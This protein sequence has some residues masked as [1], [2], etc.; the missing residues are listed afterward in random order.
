[1][2]MKKKIVIV[3]LVVCIFAMSIAS[4]TL[5]YFTDTE[6]VKNTFTIGDVK[7]TLTEAG[8]PADGETHVFSYGDLFPGFGK[9]LSPTI[10]NASVQSD[11]NDAYVAAI[12]TLEATDIG[13]IVK[14]DT[15]D[16]V[17]TENVFSNANY[18]V[19]IT[20]TNDLITI[21]V[22]ALN[23]LE[24]GDTVVLFKDVFAL[25]TWD[26]AEMD[27]IATLKLDIEAYAVQTAGFDGDAVKAI[28]TAFDGKF[29]SHK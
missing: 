2:T 21:S 9:E 22:I 12:I 24:V 29:D 25:A 18:D 19:E 5:A 3:A 1:M 17:L 6:G 27:I 14:A 10:T 26:H 15:I 11:D 16:D 20:Y 13:T 8:T 28:T 7:I 4:A 23:H